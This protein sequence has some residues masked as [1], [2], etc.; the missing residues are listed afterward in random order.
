MQN[1]PESSILAAFC[2][3]MAEDFYTNAAKLNLFE[4][5]AI[6]GSPYMI[7]EVWL[8]KIPYP[9][10]KLTACTT[11]AKNLNNESNKQFLIALPK[12][13]KA[14][15]FSVIA[16]EAGMMIAKAI[17]SEQTIEQV[18][19]NLIF[20]SPRGTVK[21]NSESH[22]LEAPIYLCETV[23]DENGMCSLTVLHPIENTVEAFINFENETKEF[24]SITSNSWFNAY[25][26]LES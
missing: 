24:A 23:K 4:N 26:C 2:G 16:C 5:Y 6:F 22:F 9:G 15:V 11:W 14:N 8:D 7:E 21:M 13:G 19:S 20:D 3:D 10:G 17:K 1:D 25:P 12:K 18:W